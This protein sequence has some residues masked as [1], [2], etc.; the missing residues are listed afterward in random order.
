GL[1]DSADLRGRARPDDHAEPSSPG[2]R[3]SREGEGDLVGHHRTAVEAGLRVLS[4]RDGFPGERG[5]VRLEAVRAYEAE[6]G[7]Y[8]SPRSQ[9]DEV[10]RHEVAGGDRARASFANRFGPGSGKASEGPHL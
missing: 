6:V 5:F 9:E 10:A 2:D 1:G 4:H 3:R 8:A 7:G